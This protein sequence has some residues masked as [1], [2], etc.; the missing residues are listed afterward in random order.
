MKVGGRGCERYQDR[1]KQGAFERKENQRRLGRQ[2]LA[3][4]QSGKMDKKPSR[5]MWTLH[6]AGNKG[7]D[8]HEKCFCPSSVLLF[9]SFPPSMRSE[10]NHERNSI[11]L[12]G[13]P[14][15]HHLR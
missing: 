11:G 3:A 9:Q 8:H 6:V 2:P 13:K 15:P 4:I 5:L 12:C 1:K 7:K 10:Q 14:T